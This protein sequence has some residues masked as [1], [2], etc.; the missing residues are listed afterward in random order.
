M[1]Q[2][3]T[4]IGFLALMA[5]VT[6]A[7]EVKGTVSCE[8][9]GIG[10]VV[11]S[12]GFR[13]TVTDKYGKFAIDADDDGRFI[14]IST[15]AGYG[16]PS[17]NG[18][19][20]FYT[21]LTE[22]SKGYDF[23]LEKRKQD[24]TKHS[25]IVIADP[26]THDEDEFPQLEENVSDICMTLAGLD[27]RYTFG[28]CLGDIVG[29]N[30]EMYPKHNEIM[31]KTGIQFRNVLGNH[32]MTSWKRSFEMSQENYEK[33]Y[34]PSYYS[35]NVGKIHY[36]VL[37]DNF[38]IRRD[39]FYIGYV[40]ESQLR[41]LEQDLSHIPEGSR[42]ILC[43]HIP[44]TLSAKDREG[45]SYNTISTTVSNHKALYDI[46]KPYRTMILSGHM[47]TGCNQT[48][49]ENIM[50]QNIAS[51]GGAWWCGNACTDGT[52]AGYKVFSIDGDEINWRYKGCGIPEDIQMRVY[53]DGQM[54]PEMAV[55]NVWDYD[56]AWKVEYIE[57][58][59]PAV[60]MERFYGIDPYAASLYNTGKKMKRSW[61]SAKNSANLF[62]ARISPGASKI[63]VRVTGRSG[64]VYSETIIM[65]TQPQKEV[66]SLSLNT[67]DA[68]DSRI[69]YIGRTLSDGRNVSFD[70]SGTMMKIR[71]AGSYLAI[72]CSDTKAN[73]FNVWVD[74]IPGPEAD[75]VIRT[76]GPDT[77]VVIA[78]NAGNGVHDVV[79]QKRTEGEQGKVTV[80][81]VITDGELLCAE[82]PGQRHIEFIGDSYTCGFGTE[83]SV[84][85]DPFKPETENCNLTYA[86]IASRYF[87]A[88]YTLVC[89]SG[90]GI[91]RNYDG[92]R[93][94]Y[95]MTDR[96]SQTFDE[97]E[98]TQWDAS[99]GRY[100]DIVV[101]YLGANDFSTEMQPSKQTFIDRYCELLSKVKQNY[102][103]NI[104]V[105]C[106]AAKLDPG[107]FEYVKS[108]C[109]ASGFKNVAYIPIEDKVHD[110]GSDLGACWH[111]NYSGQKKMASIF[112]PYI[113]TMA[114]WEMEEKPYR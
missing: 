114:G 12:D 97:E 77:V 90:Q 48:I 65:D 60:A 105:L 86:A 40:P 101:I 41:W 9:K 49:A 82:G 32:D 98:E 84:A 72:R 79:L 14:F 15:P 50:E 54:Y 33:M 47:H 103:E 87:N 69:S 89:H 78:E 99:Y 10:G 42:V 4:L 29:W 74:H 22:K 111:P 113:A 106:A 58:G 30:H 24:D 100:P 70:W 34:G 5:Q 104:P 53:A 13:T 95:T 3:A 64:K 39:Y 37:N 83:N 57:D 19:V 56:E 110:S 28:I 52:P 102:G 96:Y 107:I 109:I 51:I 20:K 2:I 8:G 46:L 45:F 6:M 85:T 75:N 76:C 35:F 55:A 25:I 16:S 63:E 26:Q 38:Y 1:K 68:S 62:R 91:S 94:G 61:V 88:D 92:F 80:H 108:A 66:S 27:D 59:K 21:P 17:E 81:N 7:R 36:V 67:F 112:I 11:V 18:T 31:A 93:P 73:Y 43:L 44:T 23:I 71:F